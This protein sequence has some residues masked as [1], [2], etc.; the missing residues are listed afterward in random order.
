VTTGSVDVRLAPLLLRLFPDAQTRLT[1]EAGN[2]AELVDQL[3]ARWPGMGDCI[4]DSTPA[5][6]RHVNIFV[7]G[8]RATLETELPPGADV[9]ILT[10]ISGG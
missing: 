5:V 10:A 9:F 8:R 7:E 2:V 4:R 1:I 3:D 6:R